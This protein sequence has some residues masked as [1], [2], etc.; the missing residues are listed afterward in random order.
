MNILMIGSVIS[1]LAVIISI[2]ISIWSVFL[3]R[4]E[5]MVQNKRIIELLELIQHGVMEIT[6][7]LNKVKRK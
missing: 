6:R 7:I 1:I 3:Q 5:T 4:R 2:A